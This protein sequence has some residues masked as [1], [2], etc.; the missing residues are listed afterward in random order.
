MKSIQRKFESIKEKNP[1][2][3][4]YT[5]FAQTISDQ[6][7]SEKLI[8]RYFNKLVDKE[9]YLPEEKKEILNHLLTLTKN[10]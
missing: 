6:S 9:D 1:D 10:S 4:S 3:T 5:S 2:W 7:F 8:R